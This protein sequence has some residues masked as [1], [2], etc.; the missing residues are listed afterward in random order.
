M[1]ADDQIVQLS[2]AGTE[3]I[4]RNAAAHAAHT[5]SDIIAV[6]FDP[7]RQLM[8]WID[9]RQKR[10]FRLVIKLK[11]RHNGMFF[12]SAIAKGNQSHEG[13]ALDV[14]FNSINYQPTALAI[15]Y[16]S[17]NIFVTVVGDEITMIAR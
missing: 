10:I 12:R 1:A 17:G 5:E 8:Y 6:E 11:H 9:S 16:L 13:Q 14:D 7:R 3:G 4:N 2:L 15:D